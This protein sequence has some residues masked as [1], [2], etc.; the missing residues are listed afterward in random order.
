MSCGS[1]KFFKVIQN[2]ELQ[3]GEL[4]VPKNFVQK[5]WKGIKNPVV[6]TIPNGVQEKLFWVERDGDV[7]FQKNWEK[8]SKL[9]KFGYIVFFKYLGGSCFKLDIFGLNCLE[10]D[11]SKFVDQV[12]SEAEFVEV[13]EPKI[14]RSKFVEVTAQKSTRSKFVDETNIAGTSQ[15]RKRGTKR[16]ATN[17][18]FDLKLT[19]SYATGYLFRIPCDFSRPYLKDFEGFARIRKLGDDRS[20]KIE[21]KYERKGDYSIVKSGWNPFTMEYNLKEV[22]TSS[23]GWLEWLKELLLESLVFEV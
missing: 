10:I 17:P 15:R 12:K 13:T 4:R 18:C 7:W 5:Y 9:L 22:L 11:Y 6:I 2:H 3:N 21:V 16:G 20:W 14:S 23:K 1:P 8:I 19:R